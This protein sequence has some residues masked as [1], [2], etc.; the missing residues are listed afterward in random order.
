VYKIAEHTSRIRIQ[1]RN[2]QRFFVEKSAGSPRARKDSKKKKNKRR[3][4]EIGEDE[5]ERE[6]DEGE[7]GRIQV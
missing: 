5:G 4:K 7:K 6:R 2:G 3:R 1:Y